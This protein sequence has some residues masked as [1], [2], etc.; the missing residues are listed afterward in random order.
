MGLFF[1][2]FLLKALL[3]T[4]LHASPVFFD[5]S[6]SVGSL[7]REDAYGWTRGPSL[8]AQAPAWR[9]GL[10]RSMRRQ[11]FWDQG[12]DTLS[13][14]GELILGLGSMGSLGLAGRVLQSENYTI[15][16]PRTTPRSGNLLQLGWGWAAG[17]GF[18]L[19]SGVA[20]GRYV[21]AA[22]EHPLTSAGLGAHWSHPGGHTLGVHADY[23]NPGGETLA[24]LFGHGRLFKKVG[25]TWGL[26]TTPGGRQFWRVGLDSR[27]AL[28]LNASFGNGEGLVIG[29]AWNWRGGK[30][31]WY[32]GDRISMYAVSWQAF[33]KSQAVAASEGDN[34]APPVIP[35]VDPA[36]AAPTE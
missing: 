18:S 26:D 6:D 29:F 3:V 32:P 35:D 11:T 25:Y 13:N 36:P 30:L 21:D 27:T 28:R 22:L 24:G 31:A 34:D 33:E 17:G 20:T 4:G 7:E 15:E 14:G 23:S 1:R 12:E 10:T 8:L 19:G 16:L 9:V 2:L 5:A